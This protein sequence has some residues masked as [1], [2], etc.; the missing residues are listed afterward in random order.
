MECN[1]IQLFVSMLLATELDKTALEELID[2]YSQKVG[3]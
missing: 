3:V 1:Q 2:W